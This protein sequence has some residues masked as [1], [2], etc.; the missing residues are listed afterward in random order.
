MGCFI[1]FLITVQ[2]QVQSS[3]ITAINQIRIEDPQFN[4]KK[5]KKKQY[6]I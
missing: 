2:S 1:W 3:Q 6:I 5:T 4:K